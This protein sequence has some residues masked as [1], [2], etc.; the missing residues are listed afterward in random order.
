M[1]TK[2]LEKLTRF[3]RATQQH[4]NLLY[5]DIMNL[6]SEPWFEFI[7]ERCIP[8]LWKRGLNSMLIAFEYDR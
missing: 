3:N 4:G 7:E 1:K 2:G 5:L 6:F 8:N